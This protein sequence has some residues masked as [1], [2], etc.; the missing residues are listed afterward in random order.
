[1]STRGPTGR[2]AA[3]LDVN[4][5][6]WSGALVNNPHRHSGL[7]FVVAL[8]CLHE[9]TP[10][11]SAKVEPNPASA[12][13]EHPVSCSASRTCNDCA[14]TGAFRQT[15]C[16]TTKLGPARA[17]VITLAPNQTTSTP[18]NMLFC[19]AGDYAM[20]FFSGPP[21]N[22]V[23]P[24]LPCVLDKS[25]QFAMCTCNAYTVQSGAPA[26]MNGYFVDINA[27]ENLDLYY[28]TVD[29]CGAD[30][31]QC[32]NMYNY[33]KFS[34]TA[35]EY[36]MAPVCE[37]IANQAKSDGSIK[38]APDADLIST[39]SY[40]MSPP[41][42][43][44]STPCP[45]DAG[46]PYAGCMTASCT[47]PS[48]RPSGT[49]N[50]QPVDC[51]CP[52]WNGPYQVGQNSQ[53]CD[54]GSGDAGA[55]VWSA[56]RTVAAPAMAFRTMDSRYVCAE[57]KAGAGNALVGNRTAIGP[58]EKF[59]LIADNDEAGNSTVSMRASTGLYVIV[60]TGSQL[61]AT[62]NSSSAEKFQWIDL[63]ERNFALKASNG[64]YVSAQITAQDA[65][66]YAD[67][68]QLGPWETFVWY[69]AQE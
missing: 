36:R 68:D 37:F 60:G 40:A 13:S 6:S 54:L 12:T 63:G 69:Q 17:N 21:T 50:G 20:C 25:G 8:S 5:E 59:Q 14:Y 35:Y 43:L 51:K 31:H 27:I 19:N 44:G 66:L 45:N 24:P 65:P 61:F 10:A 15:D 55:Y 26:P 18:T 52:T 23:G 48:G 28:Q 49:L 11:P 9:E 67:R 64:K 33:K 58:W 2:P 57:Q 1:M 32:W 62:G 38:F 7:A 41:Y 3:G 4:L 53:S 22:D 42:A 39:F 30:G 29:M 47:F 46:L 56:A 34:S 16:W